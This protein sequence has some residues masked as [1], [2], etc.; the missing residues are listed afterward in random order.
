MRLK[1]RNTQTKVERRCCAI[2]ASDKLITKLCI[3]QFGLQTRSYL[4]LC[5]QPRLIEVIEILLPV[6]RVRTNSVKGGFRIWEITKD[7]LDRRGKAVDVPLIFSTNIFPEDVQ[8]G[9]EREVFAQR[10]II[11]YLGKPSVAIEINKRTLR[12][13]C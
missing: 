13:S 12:I 2:C 1:D 5:P 4:I 10:K 7:H 3:Q 11:E 8:F 9:K 6:G